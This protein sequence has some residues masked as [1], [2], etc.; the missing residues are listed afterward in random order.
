VRVAEIENV[1][2]AALK[3]HIS[4]PALS[5]QIR[6]LEDEIGFALLE[7]TGK[8]VHLTEAGRVLL[9]EAREL[10]QRA[11]E[12]VKRARAVAIN[13][14][15]E[16]HVGYSPTPTVRLLPLILHTFQRAMP[17]VRVTLHD[18]SNDENLAGLSDGRLQLALVFLPPTP[19]S[20][21]RNLRFDELIHEHAR[22]AVSP[23]HP[24]ARRK[25]VSLEDA[26]REPFIGYNREEFPGYNRHLN[27]VFTRLKAKPRIVEEHDGFSSII[28]AIEAGRGVALV[29]ESFGFSAGNRVK[30]LRLTPEPKPSIIGI[31]APAG[32]LSSVAEKFWKCAKQAALAIS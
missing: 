13:G 5:R 20:A 7:R 17:N 31:A 21:F 22:L 14:D 8:S 27:A 29:S 16:L 18:W 6:D 19:A 30:L 3:L 11:D 28:P 1:S 26:A 24:F 10:L 4:Q 2:R 9:D 12:A 23:K 32:A 25:T 15:T